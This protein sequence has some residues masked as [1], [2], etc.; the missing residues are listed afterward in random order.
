MMNFAEISNCN[1][2]EIIDSTINASGISVYNNIE[3][4]NSSLSLNGY[5]HYGNPVISGTNVIIKGNSNIV[6]ESWT[7]RNS[8]RLIDATNLTIGENNGEITEYPFIKNTRNAYGL[9]ATNL[10]IYDRSEE[11]R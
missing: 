10:Y 9:K 11:R 4:T 5:E 8:A 3:I 6:G 7:Y 1:N 2:M